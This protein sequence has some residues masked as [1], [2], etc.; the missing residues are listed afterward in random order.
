VC[1]NEKHAHRQREYVSS[2]ATVRWDAREFLFIE[3]HKNADCALF[4]L[5]FCD[6]NDEF[7]NDLAGDILEESG[8]H[9]SEVAFCSGTLVEAS[10][11]SSLRDAA[12]HHHMW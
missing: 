1:S 11:L 7:L 12:E 8:R 2:V 6:E 5:C 9:W 10:F 3:M 4:R